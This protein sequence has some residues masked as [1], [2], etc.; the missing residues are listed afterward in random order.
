MCDKM[1]CVQLGCGHGTRFVWTR[2]VY[3]VCCICVCVSNSHSIT[4]DQQWRQSHCNWKTNY[5]LF[6]F[7]EEFS[8]T[9]LKFVHL[10]N[11]DQYWE[12][13]LVNSPA[14]SFILVCSRIL[15]F[16]LTFIAKSQ[17]SWR[18]LQ[19]VWANFSQNH[20]SDFL[21]L[22]QGSSSTME[23]LLWFG[24][25]GCH[26]SL[27][28]LYAGPEQSESNG[29][30]TLWLHSS[31]A[32]LLWIEMSHSKSKAGHW[33][34]LILFMLLTVLTVNCCLPP[35]ELLLC[36]SSFMSVYSKLLEFLSN[37]FLNTGSC[38]QQV[39]SSNGNCY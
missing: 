14:F 9:L 33:F 32:H 26:W 12:T 38:P 19:L 29:C 35:L 6:Q 13:L 25:A 15:S 22:S 30:N 39:K 1:V 8:S 7:W 28:P 21:C 27:S 16:S 31:L 34:E 3:I 18:I 24:L 11:V 10:F 20:T 2:L 23:T 17:N 5:C 37:I 4:E 36:K